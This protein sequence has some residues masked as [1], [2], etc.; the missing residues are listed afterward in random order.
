MDLF[1]G[2]GTFHF[3][4]SN[5]KPSSFVKMTSRG[6]YKEHRTLMKRMIS[7]RQ[8]PRYR[9]LQ[10]TPNVSLTVYKRFFTMVV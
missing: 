1:V 7:T 6:G 5:M 3:V 10:N 2:K 8:L 4:L 9:H